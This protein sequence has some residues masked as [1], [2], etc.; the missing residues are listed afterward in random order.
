MIDP[1]ML[2]RTHLTH[3]F[4]C[5][6]VLFCT[7]VDF[8]LSGTERTRAFPGAEGFGAFSQGGRGGRVLFVNNLNDDGAGSLREACRT[9]GPRIVVF[10]VGG[11]IELKSNLKITEPYITIAGQTAPGD[12][13]CLKNFTL[14]VKNTHDVVIRY[15]RSRPG[16]Q[17][18]V[19]QD[20]ISIDTSKNVII[21]HCSASWGTDETLS[22]T[23]KGCTN[24][25]VQWCMITESL[26][27]SVH[28]KGRHGYGSLFRLDGNVSVHHNLYAHNS[29]RNPRP[30][31]YGDV[32]RGGL[33]DFRNNVIYNWGVRAGYSAEDKITMNYIANYLKPGP[34]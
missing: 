19:E 33:L 12:G 2:L 9:K 13:I 25:T 27:N 14:W 34:S 10:R 5:R 15:I 24:V 1:M 7:V 20:A 29:S 11:I 8:A 32:R 30:G 6:L 22:V 4:F 16:D 21:D 17:M 26:D 23:G 3:R 28:H 18:K 31:T